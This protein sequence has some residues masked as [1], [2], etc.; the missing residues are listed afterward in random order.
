[1]GR[2]PWQMLLMVVGIALGV[3]VVVGVDI[4]NESANRA[5]N[6]SAETITGRATHVIT[7]G[8]Q[9]IDESVYL[10]IRTTGLGLDSAPVISEYV[11]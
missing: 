5:F 6:L 3:A 2:H 10:R 9:G 1:M 11:T 4:A 8:P 7:G